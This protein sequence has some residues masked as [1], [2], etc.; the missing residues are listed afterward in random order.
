M[1]VYLNVYLCR[2]E[3]KMKGWDDLVN[4]H[5]IKGEK[6][7]LVCSCCGMG[8]KNWQDDQLDHMLDF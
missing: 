6:Q 2:Y 4:T 7:N 5:T 8:D 1:V 3:Y